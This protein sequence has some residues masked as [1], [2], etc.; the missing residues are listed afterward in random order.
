[1]RLI[2]WK[3]WWKLNPFVY[4]SPPQIKIKLKD[5]RSPTLSDNYY[6]KIKKFG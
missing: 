4:K 3:K 6:K 2:N 5:Q 1:M